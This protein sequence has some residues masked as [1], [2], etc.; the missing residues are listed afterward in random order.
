MALYSTKGELTFEKE[1]VGTLTQNG[2]TYN[3]ELDNSKPKDLENHFREILN[4]NNFNV[5]NGVKI[6][7]VEMNEIMRNLGGKTPTEMNEFL[8]GN[9]ES[10]LNIARENPELGTM[11]LKL[12]WRDAVA[13]GSMRYEVIRQ[14]IRP[15]KENSTEGPSR[16]FDVTLLFNGL[17]L[18]Q[19]EEK[20]VDVNIK[21]AS[22]QIVK[23]KSENKYDGLYSTVQIFVALKEDTA[24]Y[25][26]NEKSADL[27]NNKFF[28]EW[29]DKKNRPVHN[30]KQFTEDFLK[31][32]MAHNLISN[33][34]YGRRRISGRGFWPRCF[35]SWCTGCC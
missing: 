25:F 7:D 24:R 13:G 6:T 22:N 19:I 8:T 35:S 11:D 27:F 34:T 29:L 23:Y 1:F 16:R 10:V 21:E 5:L 20:K 15:G 30:W 12:F 2:W 28:F 32:P 9:Y 14:A 33:Y 26:A 4:Q 31:I 17:P 18:I 3:K